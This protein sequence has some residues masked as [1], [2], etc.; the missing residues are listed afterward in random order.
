MTIQ[1][2]IN[3]QMDHFIGKMISKKQISVDEVLE[4]SSHTCAYLIRNRH[5]NN[6]GISEEEINGVM[7]SIADYLNHNFKN[8]FL[9]ED[10][11][12]LRN[13]TLELLKKP[14]FD[15]DIQE[16]FKQFYT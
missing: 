15:Q 2:L 12:E 5:I 10:F 16:Y 9:E 11:V 3:N 13:N 14:T 1:E 7:E 8:Q 6:Q 4:V